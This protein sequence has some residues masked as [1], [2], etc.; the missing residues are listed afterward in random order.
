MAGHAPFIPVLGDALHPFGEI[1]RQHVDARMPVVIP[2]PGEL[3]EALFHN[4]IT[5]A[6]ATLWLQTHGITWN[7]RLLLANVL[8]ADSARRLSGLWRAVTK[9]RLET[10]TI[11]E[12]WM[13]YLRGI[14]NADDLT[15]GYKLRGYD[16]AWMDYHKQLIRE[17]PPHQDLEAFVRHEVFNPEFVKLFQTALE[18]PAI[19]TQW[20]FKDGWVYDI[21]YPEWERTFGKKFSWDQAYWVAHWTVPSPGQ[22]YTMLHRLRRSLRD[23]RTPTDP[24][25]QVFDLDSLKKLLRI[26][27]YSGYWRDKLAA[28]S[29]HPIGI[30]FLQRLW[31]TGLI[32]EIDAA[33]IFQDQGY[34]R[35]N[36]ILQ[37]RALFGQKEAQLVDAERQVARRAAVQS[38][39]IGLTTYDQAAIELYRLSLRRDQQLLE[40]NAMA[41]GAQAD[42]ARRHRSTAMTLDNAAL[43]LRHAE[44]KS[45][46]ATLHKLYLQRRMDWFTVDAAMQR[47]GLTVEARARYRRIWDSERIAPHKELSDGQT[48]RQVELGLIPID[49][50]RQRLLDRGFDPGD[51]DALLVDA[52]LKTI[53]RRVAALRSLGKGYRAEARYRESLVRQANKQAAD[54]RAALARSAS[55]SRLE[56]WL[57][58]GLISEAEF[59]S[60]ANRLGIAQADQDRIIAAVSKTVSDRQERQAQKAAGAKIKTPKGESVASLFRW[61]KKGIIQEA[62]FQTR[63]QAIGVEDTVIA[64]YLS[65]YHHGSAPASRAPRSSRAAAPAAGGPAATAG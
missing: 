42:I 2:E 56:R 14:I 30:R 27:E 46:L 4:R 20:M 10:P 18:Q 54:A 48:L 55:P 41:P 31:Q 63:M 19:Y 53:G 16:P 62:E 15:T 13:M 40:F 9:T 47:M 7:E 58:E 21:D 39:E 49:Q 33:E 17:I 45:A 61:L 52:N 3:I 23:G 64:D 38:Y 26:N 65:E 1:S 50:A 5:E 8:P 44:I 43:A 24:S 36:A 59:R 28:I 37:A 12:L 29:Y 34:S 22:G 6:Q 32:D 60:R 35:P 51:V 11:D 25:G 57:G